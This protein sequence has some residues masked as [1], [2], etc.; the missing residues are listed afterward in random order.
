[1]PTL[2][3][4]LIGQAGRLG[5]GWMSPPVEGESGNQVKERQPRIRRHADII[6]YAIEVQRVH[7][8]LSGHGLVEIVHVGLVVLVVVDAHRL[9]VDVRL[10]RVVV[11][12][13]VGYLVRHASLPWSI[14]LDFYQLRERR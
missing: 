3:F 4:D 6:V 7:P 1:M 2:R 11:V 8:D 12:W 10:E 9:L 14:A 13:K 5:P